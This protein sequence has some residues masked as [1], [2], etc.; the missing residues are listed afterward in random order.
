LRKGEKI[1]VIEHD[2]AAKG[3][4]AGGLEIK[5]GRPSLA[6]PLSSNSTMPSLS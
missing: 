3:Y 2:N 6:H 5:E 1:Q 4:L